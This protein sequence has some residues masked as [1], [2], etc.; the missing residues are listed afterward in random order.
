MF[1]LTDNKQYPKQWKDSCNLLSGYWR[2]MNNLFDPY[3]D[4][5]FKSLSAM[6]EKFIAADF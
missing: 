1:L 2:V 5:D 3:P 4:H 6:R